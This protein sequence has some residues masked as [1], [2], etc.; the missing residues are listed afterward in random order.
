MRLN[1][2]KMKKK[3]TIKLKSNI[4]KKFKLNSQKNKQQKTEKKKS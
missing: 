4:R 3:Q 2:G 1:I